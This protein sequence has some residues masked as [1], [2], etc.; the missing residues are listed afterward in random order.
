MW[1]NDF[2]Y[3]LPK[4]LIAQEPVGERDQS[5]LLILHKK[6]GKIEHKVFADI[7]KYLRAGDLL[8]RNSSK[9]IP[10]RLLGHKEITGGSVE[11]LL[12]TPE[13]DHRWIVLG[14][15]L[16]AGA[17]IKFDGSTL[18]CVIRSKEEN[19][20]LADFNLGKKRL[21]EE[22]QKIGETPLPL[23]IKANSCKLTANSLKDRYQTVY[24]DK[25]GSVAAPTA[26]L[27]FTDD[28]L[29]EIKTN[30]VNI[31]NV[32]LHVGSGTFL[33]VREKEIKKHKMH[34]EYFSINKRTYSDI[35]AAKK[36]GRRVIAVGTT[37]ARVLETIAKDPSQKYKF[38]ENTNIL[39]D[40]RTMK[41]YNN[42]I[43]GWT[44]IFI[45]PG[46]KFKVVD[47]LITNFHLPKS[48]LLM[49]VCAFAGTKNIMNAYC[50]AIKKKY[51]FYSF[52]DAM[53]II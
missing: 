32:T 1:L 49:L 7:P 30:G 27:H 11:I 20:Y 6:S 46:C 21:L 42:E 34:K 44:D 23:Y 38:N 47:G 29:G 36:N 25:P 24:A 18:E 15:G 37:S 43:A 2:D 14:K 10:A 52:G 19:R 33:P 31:A 50:E 48:T 22:L 9:V 13:D 17:R 28:L 40:N 26:G 51:R 12:D 5:R 16:K 45:Y 4:Q 3:S 53:L 8:V 41:Q 35:V 39:G